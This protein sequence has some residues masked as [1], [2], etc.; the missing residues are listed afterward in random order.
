M[1][2]NDIIG[3]FGQPNTG[4][5]AP[6]TG[7]GGFNAGPGNMTYNVPGISPVSAINNFSLPGV[8]YKPTGFGTGVAAGATGLD[9][10]SAALAKPRPMGVWDKVG[11]GL[12]GLQ[13]IGG[14]IGAFGSLGLAKKQFQLQSDM[15][16]T[17]LKNQILAYNTALEDKARSRAAVE[18]QTA[19]QSQAYID[20]HKATK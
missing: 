20:S 18:G 12:S 6:S 11:V 5:P 2:M 8:D 16:N 19:A 7:F 17:N 13:T 10:L 1:G 9:G 4:L 15:M 3:G 14:L